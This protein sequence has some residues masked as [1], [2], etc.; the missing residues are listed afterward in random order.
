MYLDCASRVTGFGV[1]EATADAVFMLAW[2]AQCRRR[3]RGWRDARHVSPWNG[4]RY[5]SQAFVR[6]QRP[7]CRIK[8]TG[9]VQR[10]NDLMLG[11]QRC[12]ARPDRKQHSFR[13][14]KYRAGFRRVSP[15]GVNDHVAVLSAESTKRDRQ[16]S[17]VECVNRHP[18]PHVA[19]PAGAAPAVGRVGCDECRPAGLCE[20]CTRA[21]RRCSSE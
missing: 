18:R 3:K 10:I 1:A 4:K 14:R 20:R 21:G 8:Y 19:L 17:P 15:G 12:R 13:N 5:L 11:R 7:D 9:R 2:Y 6:E 16:A